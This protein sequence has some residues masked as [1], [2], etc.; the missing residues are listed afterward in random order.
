MKKVQITFKD[1]HLKMIEEYAKNLGLKRTD[2]IKLAALDFV[3]S[4]RARLLKYGYEI[5]E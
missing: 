5:K 1:E 3:K 2:F 4:N